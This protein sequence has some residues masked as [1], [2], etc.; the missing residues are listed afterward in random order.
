[1]KSGHYATAVLLVLASLPVLYI[2]AYFCLV[3]IETY[4]FGDQIRPRYL[5][6]GEAAARFFAPIHAVDE[7]FRPGTWDEAHGG[8]WP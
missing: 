5:V 4:G 2:L 7:Y 8:Y 3:R 6:G 1:M